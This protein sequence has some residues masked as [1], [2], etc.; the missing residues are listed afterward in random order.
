MFE[1][2]QWKRPGA[3]KI[4]VVGKRSIRGI[5]EKSTEAPGARWAYMVPQYSF[6][7]SAVADAKFRL[8]LS[9]RTSLERMLFYI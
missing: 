6:S 5:L 7:I 8:I 3:V 4:T 2:R 1:V 9:E